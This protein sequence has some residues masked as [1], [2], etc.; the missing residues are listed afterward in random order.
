MSEKQVSTKH[1]PPQGGVSQRAKKER[2]CPHCREGE[3]RGE[4][5]K[6]KETR[7]ACLV[8]SKKFRF[9]KKFPKQK[10]RATCSRLCHNRLIYK[11]RRSG[12]PKC[13]D[14]IC[15]ICEKKFVGKRGGGRLFCSQHCLFIGRK[16]MRSGVNRS[17][18]S[19]EWATHHVRARKIKSGVG[20][21]EWKEIGGCLG[22]L[23][24]AHVDGDYTHTKQ[25]NLLKL[26]TS[27]HK[28]LDGGK[29][30]PSS[31][32]MPRFFVRRKGSRCYE[33]YKQF[34]ERRYKRWLSDISRFTS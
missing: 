13:E 7:V 17:P 27:H 30:D 25:H 33:H 22:R 3:C 4:G 26:C 6:E 10:E 15:R 20:S 31:P 32:K 1:G 28:L 16:G 12:L 11:V 23:E 18:F 21:C 14:F 5:R 8:C 24:V 29:M 2:D 9:L 34:T 19:M